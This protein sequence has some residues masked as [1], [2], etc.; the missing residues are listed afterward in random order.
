[1]LSK[2]CSKGF[3]VLIDLI[4]NIILWR[5]YYHYIHFID[6]ETEAKKGVS[7]ARLGYVVQLING[8]TESDLG[9]LTLEYVQINHYAMLSVIGNT[10]NISRLQN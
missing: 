4:L 3:C 9:S 2:H 10:A 8:E 7:Y 6:E 1:M 5:W